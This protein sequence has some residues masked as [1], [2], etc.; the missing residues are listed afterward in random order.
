MCLSMKHK[1]P[2][3]IPFTV[4][5]ES[6]GP[7]A[8]GAQK[9]GKIDVKLGW[10]PVGQSGRRPGQEPGC[11]VL[12]CLTSVLGGRGH[13]VSVPLYSPLSVPLCE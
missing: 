10:L 12:A 9:E 13:A 4:K 11:L 2:I 7:Q 5:P 1:L 8:G 6:S 3:N